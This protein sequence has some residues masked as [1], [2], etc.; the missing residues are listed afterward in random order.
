MDFVRKNAPAAVSDKRREDSGDERDQHHRAAAGHEREN[1]RADHDDD[2]ARG[3]ER[4]K[5]GLRVEQP[6]QDETEATEHLGDADEAQEPA[7]QG[8]L[9]DHLLD[10]HD[11]LHAAGE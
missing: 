1:R 5:T 2:E 9:F 11:Q 7:R 8:Y 6:R 10:R 4:R 3:G